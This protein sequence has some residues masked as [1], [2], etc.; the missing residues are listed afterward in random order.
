M[1]CVNFIDGQPVVGS[2]YLPENSSSNW[3][4]RY[5]L[6]GKRSTAENQAQLQSELNF[7]RQLINSRRRSS[8]RRVRTIADKYYHPGQN[9]EGGGTTSFCLSC[10]LECGSPI[11]A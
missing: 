8:D 11:S 1:K 6:K 2:P 10:V 4:L 7:V 3:E 9:T 5:L